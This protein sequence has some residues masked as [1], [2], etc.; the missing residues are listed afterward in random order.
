MKL[1]YHLLQWREIVWGE[2]FV[3]HGTSGMIT[4]V[5]LS[6]GQIALTRL[7][8]L[9]P[10]TMFL[11]SWRV[12]AWPEG[13]PWLLLRFRFCCG[14]NG[15]QLVL[16]LISTKK[17]SYYLWRIEFHDKQIISSHRADLNW[18][19]SYVLGGVDGAGSVLWNW[20]EDCREDGYFDS[21]QVNS[22]Y[23]LNLLYAFPWRLM[24]KFYLYPCLTLDANFEWT[25][26]D[27]PGS[28]SNDLSVYCWYCLICK[29]T[30]NGN[31]YF[32][33]KER[34]CTP[35]NTL[36]AG[37]VTKARIVSMVFWRCSGTSATS[38]THLMR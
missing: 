13:R 2:Q 7:K 32:S 15:N 6:C 24:E 36:I 12:S 22:H 34:L 31:C 25:T 37:V 8:N 28:R 1:T 26:F 5:V 4:D 16:R 30:K 19:M 18:S 11:E 10:Q 3:Q 17:L 9:G 38:P 23:E 21:Y 14:Q 29:T 20:H 35:K 33:S 27:R